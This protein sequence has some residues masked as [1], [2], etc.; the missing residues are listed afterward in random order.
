MSFFIVLYNSLS[1]ITLDS[2]ENFL[3][4]ILFIFCSHLKASACVYAP[5][6]EKSAKVRDAN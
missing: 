4:L 6:Q 5:T 2:E 1:W 3:S